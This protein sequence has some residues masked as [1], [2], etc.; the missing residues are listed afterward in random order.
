LARRA[1]R[2]GRWRARDRCFR[3]D[4]P[5][6]PEGDPRGARGHRRRPPPETP[7]VRT[8]LAAGLEPPWPPAGRALSRPSRRPPLQRLDVPAAARRSP[9]DDD[10]RPRA[11]AVSW[12]GAEADETDA[13]RQVHER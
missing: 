4:E 8:L 3:A 12:M 13:Q 11:I 9:L 10:P 2:G 1:C 5:A 6:G 7:P